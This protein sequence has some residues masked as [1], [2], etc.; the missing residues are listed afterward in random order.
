MNNFLHLAKEAAQLDHNENS[1]WY[2]AAD[3]VECVHCEK[4]A[5][6]IEAASPNVVLELLAVIDRLEPELERLN[7]RIERDAAIIAELTL[8]GPQMS[9]GTRGDGSDWFGTMRDCLNDSIDAADCEAAEVDRLNRQI[10]KL[11]RE[12]NCAIQEIFDLKHQSL[13]GECTAHRDDNK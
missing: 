6:F 13:V 5:R 9:R 12:R 3:L 1:D 2:S 10:S 11:T 8:N 7:S 4:N